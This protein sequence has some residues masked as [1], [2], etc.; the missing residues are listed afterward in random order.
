MSTHALQALR[1]EIDA[2]DGQLADLFA[3]RMHIS[4]EVAQR[5]RDNNLSL[6]DPNREREVIDRA[7]AQVD[8]SLHGYAAMFMR[9]LITLSKDRQRKLLIPEELPLLPPRRARKTESVVCAYQGVPGAW[10]EHAQRQFFPDAHSLPMEYFED[11]FTAV[12]LGQADY[13]VLPI[14]NS[15]T[16]AIGEVYDLLK[17]FGL[18]ITGQTWVSVKHCLMA[19]ADTTLRDI[20]QVYSHP[21]GFRQCHNFLKKHNWDLTACRNTAVAAQT[22]RDAADGKSA[23][24][25]SRRAAECNGLAIVVDGIA[26]QETNRTRFVLIAAAPAYDDQ[27]DIVSVSFST[28]HRSGALCETLL[29]FMSEAINLSR[30]ESRPVSG[31]KYRFFADLQCHIENPAAIQAIRQAAATCEYFEVLGCYSDTPAGCTP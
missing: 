5:K 21:E 26:D 4:D 28:A 7:V 1:R 14:E 8:A 23:A 20:R 25:G 17:K 13:G 30:I 31:G 24:I 2:I 29:P 10:G 27:S 11:V 9:S 15:Q 19:P 18:F 22:V 3:Q 16:G 6:S 12:K